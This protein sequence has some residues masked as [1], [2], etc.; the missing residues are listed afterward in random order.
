MTLR[1][2]RN[3]MKQIL[4]IFEIKQ[5]NLTKNQEVI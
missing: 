3:V 5:F 1:S 4:G 2:R